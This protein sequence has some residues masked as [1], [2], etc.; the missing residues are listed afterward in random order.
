MWPP[1]RMQSWQM[2]R[3]DGWDPRA[4]KYINP[5]GVWH[6]GRG[7]N[8]IYFSNPLN[9]P[10]FLTFLIPSTP[11]QPLLQKTTYCYLGGGNNQPN[12]IDISYS[13]TKKKKDRFFPGIHRWVPPTE[14]TTPSSQ[15]HPIGLP[16]RNRLHLVEGKMLGKPLG[17]Y[18]PL[19][20]RGPIYTLYHVGICWGPYPLL[21][22]S[23]RGVKQLGYHPKGTSIFPMI[24]VAGGTVRLN[25][26]LHSH[27]W[28]TN[29]PG[30][31]TPP[32]I[33]PC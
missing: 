21:K 15:A 13:R 31:R 25:L 27:A 20:N 12:N 4:Y 23:D 22:D 32:G 3:L 9:N 17:W 33:R 7:D 28:S 24:F 8:P 14:S 29:P 19:N 30:S 16:E 1:P 2:S 6:P 18:P 11:P 10:H 26:L 5:G